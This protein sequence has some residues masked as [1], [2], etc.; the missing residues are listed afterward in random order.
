MLYNPFV[1]LECALF[2]FSY[3][4]CTPHNLGVITPGT[5]LTTMEASC[6]ELGLWIITRPVTILKRVVHILVAPVRPWCPHMEAVFGILSRG[7]VFL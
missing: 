2:N 7:L 1:V 6:S 5:P 3:V 4:N